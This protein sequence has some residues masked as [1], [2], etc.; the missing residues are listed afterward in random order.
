MGP[1][2]PG[3]VL[4][5]PLG[6]ST[7]SKWKIAITEPPGSSRRKSPETEELATDEHGSARKGCMKNGERGA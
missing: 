3:F 2:E 1:L 4:I 7:P 6:F 5:N